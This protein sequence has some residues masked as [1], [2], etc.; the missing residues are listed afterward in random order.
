MVKKLDK[1]LS[2]RPV[3]KQD[4][5]EFINREL[6]PIVEKLR[7]LTD[8]LLSRYLEGTGDPE[9]VVTADKGALYQR[10]DGAPGT[11]LYVKESDGSSSDWTPF[12]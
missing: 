9:G 6:A 11:L 7:L 12:A 5:E 4:M 2:A 1:K 3:L 8:A 10:Q